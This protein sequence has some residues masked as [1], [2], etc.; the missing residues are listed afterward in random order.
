MYLCCAEEQDQMGVAWMH[1][2]L[3]GSSWIIMGLFSVFLILHG[4]LGLLRQEA[5]LGAGGPAL[6]WKWV[7][8]FAWMQTA[9]EWLYDAIESS[10]SSLNLAAVL[11]NLKVVWTEFPGWGMVLCMGFFEILM[12]FVEVLMD[13]AQVLLRF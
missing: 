7:C 9:A 13:S 2:F 8:W 10:T 12:N 11:R 5:Y 1:W 3:V 4:F 6:L